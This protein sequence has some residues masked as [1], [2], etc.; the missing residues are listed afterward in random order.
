MHGCVYAA[1]QVAADSVCPSCST[2]FRSRLRLIQHLK[3]GALACVLKARLGGIPLAEGD[4]LAAL[5]AAD[6]Q[7]RQSA[8]RQGQHF[9]KADLPAVTVAS[10]G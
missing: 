5:K 7:E 8:R 10:Q 9:S 1:S 4:E 6:T 2:D 3:R